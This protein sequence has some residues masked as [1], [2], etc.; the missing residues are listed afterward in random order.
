MKVKQFPLGLF[1]INTYL[2]WDDST[3]EAAI[4]DPGMTTAAEEAKVRRFVDDNHLRVTQII[5]THLHVDHIIG[6]FA[7]KKIFGNIPV[8]GHKDDEFLGL[9][10]QDQADMFG[11]GCKIPSVKLDEYLEEGDEV[12]IG[13]G[14]LKVLHVPGH[15]P[16]SIV[17]YDPADKFLIAGD[18]LFSGSIGRADLPGGN[19]SQLVKGIKEKLLPLPDETKVF[20][21]HGPSTSIGAEKLNNPFL[22]G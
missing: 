19:M 13:N 5:N 15:S 12:R 4:I 1:G 14:V 6:N 11:L 21:G 9:R 8:K 16:G 22:I 7:S 20:S 10:A 3:G 17:L 18:V 2:V